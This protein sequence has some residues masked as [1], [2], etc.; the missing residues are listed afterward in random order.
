MIAVFFNNII[1]NCLT[2]LTNLDSFL[3]CVKC[4]GGL[5]MAAEYYIRQP[6]HYL[7]E[8]V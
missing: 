7:C 4:C 1:R 6:F 5:K 3:V 8:S 2:S